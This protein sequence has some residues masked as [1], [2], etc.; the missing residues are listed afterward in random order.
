MNK[1]YFLM[2]KENI[3]R[4]IKEIRMFELKI[5]QDELASRIG[6]DRTFLSKVESGKQNL[7]IENL[8][9]VCN[10]LG[11]TLSDFFKPFNTLELEEK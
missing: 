8:Y 9:A 11:V 3:G 2:V 1:R 10:A 6:W 7:T 4:R 5:S